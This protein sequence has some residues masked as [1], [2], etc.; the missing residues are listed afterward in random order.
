MTG[1]SGHGI[2]AMRPWDGIIAQ[3]IEIKTSEETKMVGT[4][5]PDLGETCVSSA[6]P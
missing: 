3:S 1:S 2:F 5:G 4:E 6:R